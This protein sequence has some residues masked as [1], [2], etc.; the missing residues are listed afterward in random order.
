MLDGGA[1]LLLCGGRD[2]HLS[3]KAFDLLHLLLS[4][5]PDAVSKAAI[6]DALWPLTHV[7]EANVANLVGEVRRALE[8]DRAVPRF[9]RTV[10]RFGYAFIH[11]VHS[12]AEHAVAFVLIAGRTQ[13]P[14]RPGS[15]M[16]GRS[17]RDD[18][19][20]NSETVSRRHA[21]IVVNGA[22]AVIEDLGSKNGTFVNG[23]RVI[24]PVPLRDGDVVRLGA[25]D[26][27]FCT[28]AADGQ[29]QSVLEP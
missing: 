11:P 13:W 6:Q 14:L 3:P 29:T 23:V 16:L 18:S 24:G 12:D 9:I 21:S 20:F 2:V 8:D 19:P 15:N 25:V 26:V 22:A 7:V 4:K 10:P 27:A 5:R 28:N 17:Q 1:R